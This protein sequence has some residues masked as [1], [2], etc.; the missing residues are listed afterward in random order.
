M[1]SVWGE[2]SAP[3][4]GNTGPGSSR[5][6]MGAAERRRWSSFIRQDLIA[7]AADRLADVQTNGVVVIGPRGVG[8]TTLARSVENRLE[9]TTHFVKLFGIGTETAVPYGMWGVQL[10]QL[11]GASLQ[12][13][14]SIIQ[15][16]SEQITSDAAGRR[17]VILLDDLQSVDT[18]SMG[19]LMHLVFSGVAKVMV[20]AR[21]TTDLPEDLMWLLKDRRLSELVVGAFTLHDVHELITKAMGGRVAAS[22][23]VSLFQSSA[24]NPLVLHTLIHE[25]VSR[26]HLVQHNDTWVLNSG[27]SRSPSGLLAELVQERLGRES[28]RVRHG[29]E[30]MSL[31]Q[32]VPLSL[33]LDVLGS[34]TVTA[35]EERNYL[36]IS[37][38]PGRYTS[39]AEPFLAETVRGMMGTERKAVL[40]AELIQ[41]V[42]LESPA[43]TRQ[44]LLVFAAWARDVGIPLTP[45]VALSAAKTAL[46]YSDPLLAIKFADEVEPGTAF[47]VYAALERS[48]AH[49]LLSD[50][51]RALAEILDTRDLADACLNIADHSGW[52]GELCSALLWVEGGVEQIPGL[53]GE[54]LARLNAL[55]GDPG[56]VAL[57]RRNMDLAMFQYQVHTGLLAE[58]AP[59]LEVAYREMVDV[60]YSLFCGS[61]L[62]MA[63]AATGREM[64]AVELALEISPPLEGQS[65]FVR[66][67]D[68]HIQ[69]MVLAL[70]C[71]GQ[72]RQG[73]EVLTQML[74]TLGGRSEYLGGLIELG[75]G[76]VYACAGL[77]HEA[78]EILTVAVAQLE[79]RDTY[80][81]TQLA[82]AALACALAQLEDDAGASKY[83][84]LASGLVPNAAWVNL[85]LTNYFT[86]MAQ[87]FMGDPSAA[88]TLVAAAQEDIA[89]GRH[90]LASLKLL[91]TSGRAREQ[92]MMLLASTAANRQGPMATVS[93]LLAQAALSKDAKTALAAAA[94]AQEMDLSDM[95]LRCALLALELSRGGGQ[96]RQAKDA[97]ARIDRLA[98]RSPVSP[99]VAAAEG[100]K[101]TQREL[102]VAKL[103]GR[104]LTNRDIADRMGVSI[105]TVEGHLYQVFSKLG[106]SSRS[107][108]FQMGEFW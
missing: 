63:W 82:Y 57:A 66:Q 5:R 39:L 86:L 1:A 94:A 64:D 100:V 55:G 43:F 41:T 21:T 85:D 49:A 15:G 47:A 104:G 4:G 89:A 9:A 25:E 81:C 107:Q 103:A 108:L 87:R 36:V 99:L 22:T 18:S 52:M 45:E 93:Q 14:N 24:G 12:G 46:L 77:S 30:M 62:V 37:R 26:D 95:E 97:Q 38:K 54:E 34:D 13:P 68:L 90:T 73:A 32:R 78:V 92:D 69:G 20:L 28:A 51:P 53:L 91:G 2:W 58:T 65:R 88:D 105:R 74:R 60:D 102:Q 59:A 106:L 6:E 96:T 27:R 80:F 98:P 44:E 3:R 19:V 33:V 8:K 84:A 83:L 61:L 29:V 10:A 56:E 79:I 67:P 101:L 70:A 48:A 76:L 7:T 35:M 75:L 50:Y 17:I 71:S 16:I 72:W 31:V 42:S 23:V 40:Y 11:D